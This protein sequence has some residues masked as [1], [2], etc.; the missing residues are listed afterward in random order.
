MQQFLQDVSCFLHETAN[1]LSLATDNNV[2]QIS[3]QF[4][5]EQFD[6][7]L[8]LRL[9]PSLQLMINKAVKKRQAEFIAGRYCVARA[10][11]ML[12]GSKDCWVINRKD[13]SP[14]WPKGVVGS[15]SHS[16]T[17]ATAI[18][19]RQHHICSAGIDIESLIPDQQA[20][21]IASEILAGDTVQTCDYSFSQVI[22][23]LF[24]AKETLFKALYPILGKMM[25][26]SDAF[27][28]RLDPQHNICRLALRNRSDGFGLEQ[29]E[30]DIGY[31]FD[32]NSVMTRLLIPAV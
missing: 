25:S 20:K 16:K 24:S 7:T 13:R 29:S 3:C 17:V 5:V 6:P 26:F 12:T 19:A 10:L 23:L 31:A 28:T 2:I 11:T 8:L 15:I 4:N 27:C 22:T 30:F 21:H 9:P 32:D 14:I 1:L 18:V